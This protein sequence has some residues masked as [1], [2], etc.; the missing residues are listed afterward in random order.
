M[1]CLNLLVYIILMDVIIP[2]YAIN[3]LDSKNRYL[4]YIYTIYEDKKCVAL[5]NQSSATSEYGKHS[6]ASL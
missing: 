4:I 2:F 3:K 1:A 5:E 6:A